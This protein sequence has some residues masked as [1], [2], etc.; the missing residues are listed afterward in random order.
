MLNKTQSK[1]LVKF[2]YLLL[3]PLLAGMLVYTSCENREEYFEEKNKR[4]IVTN[5]LKNAKTGEI[6]EFKRKKEGYFDMYFLGAEPKNA[7][8][9]SFN[10]LTDNEKEEFNRISERF[11][12][13]T[14][15]VAYSY[16]FFRDIDGKKSIKQNI[17]WNQLKSTEKLLETEEV[18]YSLVEE[19]PIFPNSENVSDTKSFFD[20]K[21]QEHIRENFDTKLANTLG[22]STGK[23]RI[24][25]LFKITKTGAIE[26]TGVRAPH[27][28]LEA[29][30]KRVVNL[31]PKMTPGKHSGK[32]V[33]VPYQLPIVFEVN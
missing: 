27:K 5:Y 8:E 16:I 31:L 3:V 23:K 4:R 28:Q 18:P 29:E 10:D 24:F 14:N 33:N 25:V 1:Q 21:I 30:A 7:K 6:K 9:I 2:K 19:A 32:P 22:L 11:D 12:S 13:G 26:I 20:K 15:K 17:H